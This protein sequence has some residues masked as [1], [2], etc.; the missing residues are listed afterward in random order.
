[1]TR[2]TTV[3]NVTFT[4]R[5]QLPSMDEA[6]P[7]GTYEIE[8]DEELLDTFTRL[9]Y[10]RAATRIWLNKPGVTRLLQIDPRDLE[11]ALI[12]DAQRITGGAPQPN[13]I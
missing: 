10:R 11:A 7:P 1:M 3:A 13:S 8:T 4:R 9:A 2:R 5:F 12:D 6:Y